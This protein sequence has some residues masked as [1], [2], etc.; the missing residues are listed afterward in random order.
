MAA[1]T[2]TIASL[3]L[4]RPNLI[5]ICAKETK[6]EFLKLLRFPM[7]S[8]STLVFPLMFYILFGLVMGRQTI[9]NITTTL[10]LIASYGTFAVMGASLFGTAAVLSSERGLGWLEV[11]RASPMPIF[12]YFLAKVVISLIFSTVDVSA[13]MLLGVAFGGVHLSPMVAAKLMGTLVAGSIPFCAMGLAM[14]YFASP[15]SAP[16]VINIFYLPMSFCSG[17]WIPIMF[18]PH[19]V[20]KL[21]L[22]LPAYHLSQLALNVVGAGQGGPMTIHWQTLAGFTLLCIGMAW[23]GHQRDQKANG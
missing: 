13:L 7:F 23:F 6:Y 16:A 8:V 17:L 21:A 9:G 22:A 15:N 3:P 14:G 10:Y 12:A 1:S 4:R 11:K 18:L 19:F 5:T 2:A 20:Q